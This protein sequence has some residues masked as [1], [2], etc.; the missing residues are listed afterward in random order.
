MRIAFPFFVFLTL[1]APLH[2]VAADHGKWHTDTAHGYE[3]YWIESS[4]GARFTIWC[5]PSHAIKNTLID[6]RIKGRRPA[7]G[8]TVLVEL[9]HK[10]VKFRAADDGF[11]YNDC[12][13]CSDNMTYFWHRL[14]SAVKF[15]VQLEDRRYSG[16]SLNGAR[17]ALAG[18]VCSRQIAQNRR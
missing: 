7:P 5:P 1:A 17:E 4:T 9:D 13:A 16:F 15:A 6:I 11:I 2:A 18:S 12:P 8:T 3:R 14:R 10:L